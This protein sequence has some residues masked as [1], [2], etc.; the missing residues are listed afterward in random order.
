MIKT[1]Y[2]ECYLRMFMLDV[3]NLHIVK[4]RLFNTSKFVIL[5]KIFT[6]KYSENLHMLVKFVNTSI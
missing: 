1:D 5:Y 4:T 2:S 3:L 6:F